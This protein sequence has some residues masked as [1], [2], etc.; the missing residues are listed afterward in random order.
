MTHEFQLK[1]NKRSVLTANTLTCQELL[2]TS[3]RSFSGCEPV[4]DCWVRQIVAHWGRTHT[5]NSSSYFELPNRT[6]TCGELFWRVCRRASVN[7][8]FFFF[9]YAMLK[10][11]RRPPLHRGLCTEPSANVTSSS[12]LELPNSLLL[13]SQDVFTTSRWRFSKLCVDSCVVSWK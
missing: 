9:C 5:L 6:S 3:W 8:C 4:G 12:L 7:K 11:S 2:Q 1:L 13:W 10:G